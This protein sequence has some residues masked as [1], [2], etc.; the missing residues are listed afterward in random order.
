MGGFTQTRPRFTYRLL[1]ARDAGE[2][3]QRDA[4]LPHLDDRR[5]VVKRRSDELLQA[6]ARLGVRR[7]DLGLR[8]PLASL[9]ERDSRTHA[10]GRRLC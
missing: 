2:V 6:E 9:A 5:Q 7:I 1:R 4:A 3:E 8:A 10:I